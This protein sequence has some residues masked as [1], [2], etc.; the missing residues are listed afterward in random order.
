LLLL[1]KLNHCIPNDAKDL[2]RKIFKPEIH[3]ITMQRILSHPYVMKCN[4]LKYNRGTQ[5]LVPW[6]SKKYALSSSKLSSVMFIAISLKWTNNLS[7][8]CTCQSKW[9]Q[10]LFCFT[11]LK[12]KITENSNCLIRICNFLCDYFLFL[13]WFVNCCGLFQNF[14]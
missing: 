4:T 5:S 14:L 9:Q 8:G 13:Y 2:L 3:R 1:W 11:F 7:I 6:K 12:L 10:V